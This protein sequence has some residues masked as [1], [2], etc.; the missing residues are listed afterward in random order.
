MRSL[1]D[2]WG[3]EGPDVAGERALAESARELDALYRAHIRREEDELFPAARTSLTP[4]I[5]AVMAQEMADRRGGG[6][7]GGRRNH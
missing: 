3:D 1:V 7:G 5:L 6:S 2:A 4:E